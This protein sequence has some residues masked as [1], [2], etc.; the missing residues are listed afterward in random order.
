MTGLEFGVGVCV[1]PA[2]IVVCAMLGSMRAVPWTQ[3]DQYIVL[4]IA[5]LT[6]VVWLG[7]KHTGIPVPQFAYGY[8]LQKLGDVEKKITADPKEIEVRK[9]FAD[10]AAAGKAALATPDKSYAE[11]K[12]K[13]EKNLADLK[14]ANAPADKIA[15]AERAV[16]AFRS[17]RFFS[18]LALPSAYDFSGVAGDRKSTRPNS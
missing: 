14:A 11:G 16:A 10:R 8:T 13:V 18:T 6:P 15:D 17:A 4:I 2:G 7:V 3:V 9:I 12:A 5:Y 1:G